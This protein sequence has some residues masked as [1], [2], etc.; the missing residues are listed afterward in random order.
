VVE[1][2]Q[3]ESWGGRGLSVIFETFEIKVHMGG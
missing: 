1:L 2:P 3:F